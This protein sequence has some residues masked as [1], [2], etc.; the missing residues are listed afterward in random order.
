MVDGIIQS[1][2]FITKV[3]KAQYSDSG[4]FAG[5]FPDGITSVENIP[6]GDLEVFVYTRSNNKLVAKT[7][8]AQDGTW[9]INGMN[10][11]LRYDVICRCAGHND[12]IWSNVSPCVE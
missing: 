12:M 2:L 8:S 4:Y 5:D 3:R 11:N 7:K 1:V 10:P 6:T 9:R